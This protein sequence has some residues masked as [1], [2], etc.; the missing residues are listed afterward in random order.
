MRLEGAKMEISAKTENVMLA[1][2]WSRERI[3]DCLNK[4][5]KFELVRFIDERYT[6][7]FFG[8]INCLR[9]ARGNEQG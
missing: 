6:E 9:Q 5:H 8:P 3:L 2:N 1:R 7:R 4:E